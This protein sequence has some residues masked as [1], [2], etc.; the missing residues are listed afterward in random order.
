MTRSGSRAAASSRLLHHRHLH[1]RHLRLLRLRLRR[2]HR[3]HR[4]RH[5]RRIRRF[6]NRGASATRQRRGFW[7]G[8]TLHRLRGCL[9]NERD[10]AEPAAGP[11]AG[12]TDS[13]AC[14]ATADRARPAEGRCRREPQPAAHSEAAGQVSP[15]SPGPDRGK[16][17]QPKPGPSPAGKQGGKV[18]GKSPGKPAAKPGSKPAMKRGT[19]LPGWKR[20][21]GGIAGS[22]KVPDPPKLPDE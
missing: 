3:R 14:P 20:A 10:Q 2:H 18:A 19:E 5:R 16:A 1:H 15:K 8:P 22:S 11:Q 12:H 17:S 13:A 21:E 9:T 7:A 6:A 4:P